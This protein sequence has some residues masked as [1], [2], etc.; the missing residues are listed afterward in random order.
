MSSQSIRTGRSG[1]PVRIIRISS[2]PWSFFTGNRM[3]V[4]FSTCGFLQF[5]MSESACADAD[6]AAPRQDEEEGEREEEGWTAAS[7][8]L[9]HTMRARSCFHRESAKNTTQGA[10][11]K[12]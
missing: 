3:P 4:R 1:A 6:D 11:Q 12:D 5:E 7:N 9:P 2:T 10:D 8:D